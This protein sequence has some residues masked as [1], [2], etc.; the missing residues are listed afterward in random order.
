[1][2][3]ISSGVGRDVGELLEPMQN[4]LGCQDLGEHLRHYFGRITRGRGIGAQYLGCLG[5]NRD[6]ACDR[7][8]G[9]QRFHLEKDEE[10]LEKFGCQLTK[11]TAEV[12]CGSSDPFWLPQSFACVI[13]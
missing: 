11:G 6:D 2:R 1:M 8:D 12:S 10:S 5:C 13:T 9:A 4:R 7:G 3:G